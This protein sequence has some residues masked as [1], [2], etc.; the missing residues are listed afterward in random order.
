MRRGGRCKEVVPCTWMVVCSA[1]GRVSVV[2]D[3][4]SI[5]LVSFHLISNPLEV[6]MAPG[7]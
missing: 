6:L 4:L 5:D 1:D 2:Q 3:A 7:K